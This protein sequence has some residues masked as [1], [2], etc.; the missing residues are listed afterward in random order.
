MLKLDSKYSPKILELEDRVLNLE[1]GVSNLKD[2]NKDIVLNI[3]TEPKEKN[4]NV[5]PNP[6]NE[7]SNLNSLRISK[8]SLCPI[9]K[10]K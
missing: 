8:W 9:T 6:I 1:G 7:K 4:N 2:I 5:K 10:K 3:L